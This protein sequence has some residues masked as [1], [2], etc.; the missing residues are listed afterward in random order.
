VMIPVGFA[1]PQLENVRDSLSLSSTDQLNRATRGR[2]ELVENG[3][4]I[5]ADNP[6]AGVG[7]GGFEAAYRE[8]V[9]VS[10]REEPASHTTP[11]TVAAET[12]IV[13]LALFA[14]LVAAALVLALRRTSGGPAAA[15]LAGLAVGLGFFAVLVHSLFYSAFIED[16]MTWCFL[17]LAA[18]AAG[19][20]AD[21]VAPSATPHA[22][23]S[24]DDGA[25]SPPRR[26]DNLAI[27]RR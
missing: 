24:G 20:V 22:T 23:A 14:W 1:A 21:R 26:P 8:R 9:E 7:I 16:P 6:L 13:G 12:G 5:A 18:L 2:T 3:L 25:A 27:R 17:G 19:A 15:R 10:P 11:V 4:R